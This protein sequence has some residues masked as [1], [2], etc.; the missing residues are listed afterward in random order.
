MSGD[1]LH[2][3]SFSLCLFSL[4]KFSA[5]LRLLICVGI[6]RIEILDL[7]VQCARLR[8]NI[9]CLMNL[10]DLIAQI[11]FICISLANEIWS[12]EKTNTTQL[13]GIRMKRQCVFFFSIAGEKMSSLIFLKQNA[14]C[15]K[16]IFWMVCPTLVRNVCIRHC[17]LCGHIFFGNEL[18][19]KSN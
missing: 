16:W 17:S 19:F 18:K 6:V 9:R 14:T 2:R 15:D 11:T 3:F 10:N 1:L 13:Q 8:L 12:W 7:A 4:S 5:R